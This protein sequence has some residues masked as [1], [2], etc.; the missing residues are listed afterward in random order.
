MLTKTQR[1]KRQKWLF[2]QERMKA[3]KVDLKSAPFGY[4]F[5]S[6][7]EHKNIVRKQNCTYNKLKTFIFIDL[8]KD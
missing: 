6:D 3:K 4:G 1:K 5:K 2:R 8:I 7:S